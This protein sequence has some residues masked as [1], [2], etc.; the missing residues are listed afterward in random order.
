MIVNKILILCTP[1]AQMKRA[2]FSTTELH[3]LLLVVMVVE[4]IILI[5]APKIC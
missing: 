5:V 1:S 3:N 4:T 2:H